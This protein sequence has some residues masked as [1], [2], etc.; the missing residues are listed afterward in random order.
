VLSVQDDG[1][2]VSVEDFAEARG[3]LYF[4]HTAT[5]SV[6]FSPRFLGAPR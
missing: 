6:I 2:W 5:D 4:V 3:L 1:A